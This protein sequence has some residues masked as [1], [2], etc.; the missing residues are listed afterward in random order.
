MLK[1]KV[2]EDGKKKK[3]VD[4]DLMAFA[5]FKD[6]GDSIK[7]TCLVV[8]TEVN[9]VAIMNGLFKVVS[10]AIKNIAGDEEEELLLTIAFLSE[11]NKAITA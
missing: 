5:G 11:F 7:T 4:C 9:K 1:V 10:S 3:C 6:T 2:F 8:G